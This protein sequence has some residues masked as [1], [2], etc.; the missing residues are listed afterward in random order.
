ML[1]LT[2]PAGCGKTR[3]ALQLA[4]GLFEDYPN[5]VAWVGLET[6]ADPGL[7]PQALA[8]A[9][10]VRERHG[11]PV[12]ETL[13]DYLRSKTVFL[14]LDNCEHV[15]SACARL[16]DSLLRH[17]PTVKILTTSREGLGVVGEMLYPVPPLPVPDPTRLPP[18]DHLPRYDAV[19]LFI[20]RAVAIV[21]TF[22]VTERNARAVAQ[23]CHRLD[24]IPLALELAAA[25]VKVLGAEYIS[26]KLDDRFRLLTG[27]SLTAVPRHQTLRAA[28]DWSFDL[29]QPNEQVMLHRLSV[30]AGGCTIETAEAVCSE[31]GIESSEVLDLL[32]R[33]IDKSLVLA[34]ER[35][36]AVR[37]RMLETVRQYALD[38]LVDSGT[39]ETLRRRHCAVFRDIAEGAAERIGGPDQAASIDRLEREHD[40][41]RAGLR[42][43]LENEDGQTELRLIKALNDFWYVRGYWSESL[44]WLE[45][46]L[47]RTA[48]VP[49]ALRGWALNWAGQMARRL[50]DMPQAK[51]LHEEAVATYRAL[52]EMSGLADA[53]MHLGL[54]EYRLSAYGRAATLLEESLSLAREVDDT[55]HVAFSLYLLGVVAR[56]RGDYGRAEKLVSESLAMS[57][58]PGFKARPAAS[59]GRLRLRSSWGLPANAYD[60]LGL[61]ALCQGGYERAKDLCE[62]ALALHK[63]RDFKVG[64]MAS[65]NSLALV[66]SVEGD[67]E[68]AAALS[69]ESLSLSRQMGD[70]DAV[71]RSLNT[72]GRVAF[73]R[74]DRRTAASLHAESLTIF[75]GLGEK[76]GIA[77]TLERLGVAVSTAPEQAVRLFAA[78]DALRANIGAVM[79][80]YDRGDYDAVLTS[81]R[82]TLGEKAFAI[83]WAAGRAM[84]ADRAADYAITLNEAFASPGRD[85]MRKS[86]TKKPGD[87]LAPR[88]R[89]IAAL[90]AQGLSNRAIAT[91]LTI[92]ERTA[93][94]HIQHILNKLRGRS[95]SQIAAWAVQHGLLT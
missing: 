47:A 5:G 86:A 11:H 60:G 95:R 26:A 59:D 36:G 53:L 25:R 74:G 61:V 45:P 78:A 85:G 54:L 35:D 52:G 33:L 6:L 51:A 17:C 30:F 14:L 39:A 79:P 55:Q 34:E 71:A 41:L 49:S 82:S 40:N 56:L 7:V 43:A 38:R 57:E 75:R 66:A 23:I 12:T 87:L 28:M 81:A 89:E 62:K 15:L 83:A 67:C 69:E 80:P 21:P 8:S 58:S 18:L 27:G 24:G 22:T 72:L 44:R 77:Q 10:G 92:S 32:T 1:T 70:K 93:E 94:A 13:L 84:A 46:V 88:E 3:L 16:C 90:V 20:D 2:G 48:G 68:R 63:Q 64:T 29:L 31:D 91:R 76:L 65:L 50:G 42:W 19:Q 73:C 4:S 37:Y 9:M